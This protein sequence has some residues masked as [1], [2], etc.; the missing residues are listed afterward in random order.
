M[1]RANQIH[2]RISLVRITQRMSLKTSVQA[3]QHRSRIE[4]APIKLNWNLEFF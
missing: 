4:F 3:N 2:N 1:N